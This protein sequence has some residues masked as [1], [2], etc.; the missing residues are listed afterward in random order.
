MRKLLA[1]AVCGALALGAAAC[2][3]DDDDNGGSSSGS[4]SSLSGEIAGAGSSAQQAA[5]EAWIAKFQEANSGVTISYDPVGSGAGREQFISGGSVYAGSD[6]PYSTEENELSKA[7]SRCTKSGGTLVQVPNYISPIAIVYNLSGVDNLQLSPDTIAGIFAQKIKNWNDPKIKADNPGV[8][9]PDTKITPVNRSDKSGTT[10]N[11]TDYM[12]KTAP[13]IWTSEPDDV[14]PL[15]GGEAAA[16]TSGEVEAVGQGDGA[17]GYADESQAGDLGVAKIKV[18]SAWVK[19]SADGAAKVLELSPLDK[20]VSDSKTIF[21]YKIDRTTTEAGTYPLMLVSYL[22]GCTKY[23]SSGTTNIV[24]NYFKY[25]IS[26][27]GQQAAA[28]NAG[29]APLTAKVTQQIQPAVNAIGG[30]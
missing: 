26:T 13:S 7:K 25:V 11:F 23:D 15:K 17:I 29:S 9:L 16:Q 1:F 2:G 18:G 20:D 4:S 5:Q 8:N 3:G 19:P 28:Q 12:S 22:S 14:W 10:K 21:A 6:S 24:K 27:D 30:S